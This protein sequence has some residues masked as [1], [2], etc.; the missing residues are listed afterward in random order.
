[1]NALV[2]CESLTISCATGSSCGWCIL[3]SCS[4]SRKQFTAANRELL[5]KQRKKALNSLCSCRR[6]S[7]PIYAFFRS[8]KLEA[9]GNP[10]GNLCSATPA[11]EATAAH[12]HA[13]SGAALFD[14]RVHTFRRP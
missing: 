7:I 8:R 9:T 6:H 10:I 3:S 4:L 2:S 1:M 11:R 14:A 5:E 13:L 12:A